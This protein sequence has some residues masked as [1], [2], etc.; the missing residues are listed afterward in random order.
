MISFRRYEASDGMSASMSRNT[1]VKPF[2]ASNIVLSFASCHLFRRVGG[3][4]YP[5]YLRLRGESGQET[6]VVLL[7]AVGITLILGTS[8]CNLAGE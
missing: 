3:P 2:L 5:T 1:S 4:H 8:V 6:E 7:M